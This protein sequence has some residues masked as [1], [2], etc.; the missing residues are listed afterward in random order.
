MSTC[1]PYAKI[2]VVAYFLIAGYFSR[3]MI[4]LVLL[5][6]PAAAVA[7]GIASACIANWWGRWCKL[8]LA[9]E[10]NRFQILILKRTR[11][12]F[13]LE[14]LVFFSGSLLRHYTLV[15]GRG[16]DVERGGGGAS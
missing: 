2:F 11:Q 4:R 5:L 3:K 13:Q 12:W 9:L 1:V 10:S 16:V 7:A 15:P 6:G 14:P 8:T